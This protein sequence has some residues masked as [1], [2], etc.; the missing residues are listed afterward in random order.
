MISCKQANTSCAVTMPMSRRAVCRLLFMLIA[1]SAAC[2]APARANCA[3]PTGTVGARDCS[4]GVLNYCDG[5]NWQ[6]FATSGTGAAITGASTCSLEYNTGSNYYEYYNGTTYPKLS[7]ARSCPEAYWANTTDAFEVKTTSLTSTAAIAL[8]ATANYGK[9][10]AVSGT[11]AVIGEPGRSGSKGAIYVLNLFNRTSP[12]Q[13]TVTDPAAAASDLFGFSVAV[14]GNIAVVG[15]PHTTVNPG[16]HTS[17]GYVYIYD[18]STPATPVLKASIADPAATTNDQFGYSVAVEGSKLVVGQLTTGGGSGSAY[19]F[20]ITDPA[21]YIQKALLPDP[22]LSVLFGTSVAVSGDVALVGAPQSSMGA[23]CSVVGGAAFIYDLSNWASVPTTP[24]A[25]I[26]DPA[27]GG[28][29]I[30]HYGQSVALAKVTPTTYLALIGAYA[31]GSGTVYI[32]QFTNPASPSRWANTIT[33]PDTGTGSNDLFSASVSLSGYNA[34]IGSSGNPNGANTG[35]AYAYDLIG[36][37]AAGSVAI[38]QTLTASDGVAGDYFGYSVSV[39]DNIAMVGAYG[40]T[41]STIATAGQA[42]ELIEQECKTMSCRTNGTCSGAGGFEYVPWPNTVAEYV[43]DTY[44]EFCDGT[45]WNVL[46]TCPSLSGIGLAFTDLPLVSPSTTYNSDIMSVPMDSACD[47]TVSIASHAAG[48]VDNVNPKF[49]VC[50][51]VT[52]STNPAFGSGSQTVSP[53]QFVQLQMTSS[54]SVS[55]TNE[56]TL[57]MGAGVFVPWT[58]STTPGKHIF[59]AQTAQNGA[60]TLTQMDIDCDTQGDAQLGAATYK[61]WT[62]IQKGVDDPNTRSTHYKGVYKD[63]CAVQS[64]VANNYTGLTS[65]TLLHGIGCKANQNTVTAGSKLWTNVKDNGDAISTTASN[66]TYSCGSWNSSSGLKT[67]AYGLSGATDV[68]WTYNGLSSWQ[69]CNVSNQ[70]YCIE[71]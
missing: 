61:A 33:N 44:Y 4:S 1:L 27:A 12:T 56:M 37:D 20:D 48:A 11:K 16:S 3:S 43:N 60:R 66:D 19:I 63:T 68:T 64:V 38:Q 25:T 9:A 32:Y 45:S 42:Y 30:D 53:G 55:T 54:A 69:A 29:S 23:G 57:Q 8:S 65:G 31:R 62:A 5:T 51:D 67:G 58:I 35:A 52:C 2:P 50:V 17:A 26:C 15:A 21:N 14:S 10:V 47:Q 18:I 41:V 34:V 13:V 24:A 36:G 39:S 22:N 40:K 70:W 46:G 59:I 6:Q 49:R 71:Q 7:C 28:G